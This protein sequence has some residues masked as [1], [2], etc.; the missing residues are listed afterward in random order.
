MKEAVTRDPCKMSGL[1]TALF[2]VQTTYHILRIGY[3]RMATQNR[4]KMHNNARPVV[5]IMLRPN[6]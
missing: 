3:V 2:S 6:D 5:Q 4:I 1:K